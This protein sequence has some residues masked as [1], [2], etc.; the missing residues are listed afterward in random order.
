MPTLLQFHASELPPGQCR[1]YVAGGMT[2][3][4]YNLAN[5]FYATQGLCSH[6][7]LPLDGGKFESNV[8]Q[9]PFHDSRFNI[10]TGK[11]LSGPAEHGLKTFPVAVDG[12][13][14]TVTLL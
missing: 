5:T 7:D 8:I 2:V 4:V 11:V 6:E 1:A 3:L 13:T 12:G 14:V 10:R 9:C